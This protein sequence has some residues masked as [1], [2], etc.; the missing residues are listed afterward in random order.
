MALTRTPVGSVNGADTADQPAAPLVGDAYTEN[1]WKAMTEAQRAYAL[2]NPHFWVVPREADKDS[3]EDDTFL[4]DEVNGKGK[5]KGDVKPKMVPVVPKN[6]PVADYAAYLAASVKVERDAM[7]IDPPQLPQRKR[8]PVTAPSYT[9]TNIANVFRG[10]NFK[11]CPLYEGNVGVDVRRWLNTLTINLKSRQASIDI[12]HLAGIRLL[13]GKAYNDFEDAT[14]NNQEPRNW[15]EFCD[16]VVELNPVSVSKQM[17]SDEF[18]ALVQGPTE[19]CQMFYDRFRDWQCRAR[20]YDF[21]Y[22]E[23]TAFVAALD[24]DR[25]YR[26]RHPNLVASTSTSGK[27]SSDGGNNQPKKKSAGPLVCFNCGKENHVSSKCPEPKTDKQKAYE[28]KAK[29][30]LK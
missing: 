23:S 30:T 13:G 24:E 2:A 18:D 20:G 7:D 10:W 17:I 19:S 8:L 15:I 29:L 3:E 25:A 27:R 21:S 4:S 6:V 28:A 11:N 12:W 26:K 9:E 5:A 14:A 22:D 1:E 16:W